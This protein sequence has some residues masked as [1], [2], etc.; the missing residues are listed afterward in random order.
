[1]RSSV[2]L[3]RLQS[4][5]ALKAVNTLGRLTRLLKFI[6]RHPIK[7]LFALI[8]IWFALMFFTFFSFMVM[9]QDYEI[10]D[11]YKRFDL[12][13]LV[14]TETKPFYKCSF[15]Y[16][17]YQYFNTPDLEDCAAQAAQFVV[18]QTN[19]CS[20]EVDSVLDRYPK[21]IRVRIFYYRNHSTA[22]CA[23]LDEGVVTVKLVDDGTPLEACPPEAYPLHK[24]MIN[25]PLGT[26]GNMCAR[27]LIGN[28]PNEDAEDKSCA[29]IVGND[30]SFYGATVNKNKH[31]DSSNINC[32]ENGTKFC[33]TTAS[34]FVD[35]DIGENFVRYSPVGGSTFTGAECTDV[36]NTSPPPDT[37]Q[38]ED[39]YCSVNN[40][41][42]VYLVECPDNTIALNWNTVLALAETS[43][44]DNQRIAAIESTF[45]TKAEINTLV[46]QVEQGQKGE[47]GDK[48]DKGDT[49]A[50]GATGLNGLDGED[51]EDGEDCSI[52]QTTEG[53]AITCGASTATVKSGD[54]CTTKTLPN[55]DSQISCED[56]TTSTING[57][58]ED[59]I[60]SALNTQLTE[61]KKQTGELEGQTEL[62][63]KIAEYDGDKPKIDYETKPDAYTE[64]A[65]FDWDENNF[66]TVMEEHIDAMQKLPLFSAIDGFFDTTFSGSCPVWETSVNV[67]DANFNIKL[68]QFCSSTVQSLLPYIRAVLM[69]VA[70]FFAWRIAIE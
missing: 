53:A 7:T 29:D 25:W 16:N 51:G 45:M 50:R 6:I 59:G 46:E 57:I 5:A 27:E 21:S 47:K 23:V 67:M 8:K 49:G 4:Y 54:S 12:D 62:L 63:G 35:T 52:I 10:P 55:G 13:D 33:E 17:G 30:A 68:D 38:P 60:I 42:G 18:S 32:L 19:Y 1:M 26:D 56:G 37:E 24:T 64:I 2:L 70:G 20:F 48:G 69:L 9:A 44:L 36:S 11:S 66:G 3:V 40:S 28:D 41:D 43:N 31:P 14:Q 39:K 22:G 34:V 61:M 65:E 58:D 15:Y